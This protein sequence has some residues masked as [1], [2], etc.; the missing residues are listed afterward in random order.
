MFAVALRSA[1]VRD[2][3]ARLYAGVGIVADSN[4]ER[5]WDETTL[6]FRPM[7]NALGLQA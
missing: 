7:L 2:N 5:E 3:H 4:P 6:K 1:V